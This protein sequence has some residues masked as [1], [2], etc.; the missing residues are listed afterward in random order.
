[1]LLLFFGPFGDVFC[2]FVFVVGLFMFYGC[3]IFVAV[4]LIAVF[5][6]NVIWQNHQRYAKRFT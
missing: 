2:F 5:F 1:M 3:V 6:F 4:F